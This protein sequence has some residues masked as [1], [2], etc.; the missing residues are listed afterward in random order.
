MNTSP[1]ARHPERSRRTGELLSRVLLAMLVLVWSIAPVM[2]GASAG[3][4]HPGSPI[5]DASPSVPAILAGRIDSSSLVIERRPARTASEDNNTPGDHG[6][7]LITHHTAL[8][9]L[10]RSTELLNTRTLTPCARRALRTSGR[11]PPRA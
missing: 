4:A 2:P 6:P 5:L 8:P 10:A 1:Q 3:T 7:A 11:D 9:A